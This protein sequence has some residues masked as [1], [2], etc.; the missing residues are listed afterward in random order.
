[1]TNAH[2]RKAR[3]DAGIHVAVIMDGNGR[4]AA[5][6]GLPRVAGHSEGAAA[7]RRTVESAPTLGIGTLT[8]YAFS[9]DNWKRPAREVAALMRLFRKHL[10]SETPKLIENGVRLTIIGRRDRLAESL[11][12][13]I[14]AAE[15]ATREGRRLHLRVAIDYSARDLLVRAASRCDPERLPDREAFAELL[16]EAYGGGEPARDVDLLI[17]TGG[18]QRLSDFLLWECA[19]AELCFLECMWPEFGEAELGEAVEWF[20]GRQRRYGGL[21]TA[22]AG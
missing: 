3:G 13:A 21:V 11:Q 4:W 18:E 2:H 12:R 16:G 17:R 15:D 19:Y 10:A 5:A 7:V 1:M 14:A 6:R 8:L 22:A 9:S 20:H